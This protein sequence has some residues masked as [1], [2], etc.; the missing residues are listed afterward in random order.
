MNYAPQSTIIVLFFLMMCQNKMIIV[1]FV[2]TFIL[3]SS[4]TFQSLMMYK[5]LRISLNRTIHMFTISSMM[6]SL[7]PRLISNREVTSPQIIVHLV[8]FA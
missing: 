5:K 2:F 8:S 4:L 6:S 3:Y 7:A 1:M